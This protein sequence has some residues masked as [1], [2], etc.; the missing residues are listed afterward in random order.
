[1]WNCFSTEQVTFCGGSILKTKL[2]PTM[3]LIVGFIGILT[4]VGPNSFSTTSLFSEI[5]A[6][7]STGYLIFVQEAQE[8]TYKYSGESEHSVNLRV[9]A[10]GGRCGIVGESFG[11]HISVLDRTVIE[12]S[13]GLF[14]YVH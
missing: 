13:V 5:R 4:I 2:V 9:D 7:C 14:Q 11:I 8:M 12:C 3:R 10:H 6:E 1:M